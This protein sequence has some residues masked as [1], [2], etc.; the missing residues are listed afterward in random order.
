MAHISSLIPYDQMTM[1]DF[2]DAYPE[3]AIDPINRPTFWPHSPDEQL[4]YEGDKDEPERA[5]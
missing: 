2:R 5:H 1:E 4:G 3:D